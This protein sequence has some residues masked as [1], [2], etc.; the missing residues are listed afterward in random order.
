MNFYSTAIIKKKLIVVLL[1]FPFFGFGHLADTGKINAFKK[2]IFTTDSLKFL[3]LDH[4]II[5]KTENAKLEV[6]RVEKHPANPLFVEDKDWEMRFDN[7]YG[8]V[9]FDECGGYL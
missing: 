5:E 7:L 9:I 1:T 2:I 6:G 3:L 4:R 8:N